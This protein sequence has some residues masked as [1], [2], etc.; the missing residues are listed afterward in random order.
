[1]FVSILPFLSHHQ[2]FYEEAELCIADL[3]EAAGDSFE[4]EFQCASGAVQNSFTAYVD[5]LEDLRHANEE[6]LQVYNDERLQN[7]TNL[8]KLRQQLD[9]IVKNVM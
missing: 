9:E 6:Q 5:L 2:S 3:K 1:L 7:A 4:E 8:K